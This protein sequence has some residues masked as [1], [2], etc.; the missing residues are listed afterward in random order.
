MPLHYC[1][2]DVQIQSVIT[3]SDEEDPEHTLDERALAWE[4]LYVPSTPDV[5]DPNQAPTEI[6][7]SHPTE[8]QGEDTVDPCHTSL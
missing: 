1:G 2:C 7:P 3:V 5:R 4:A 6:A 8:E